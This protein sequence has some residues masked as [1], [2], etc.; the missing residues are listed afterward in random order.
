MIRKGVDLAMRLLGKQFVTGETIEEALKSASP[1][2]ARGYRFSYDML[3][4]AAMTAAD[5]AALPRLLRA[6]DPRHR[7]GEPGRGI[8]VGPGI[9]VK[10]SA[11]HPR[12]ARAQHER[13]MAELLPRLKALLLLARGYDIGLNIDAEEADRLELSLDLLEAL[14]FDPEL[15]GWNGIG[16]VVQA[17]QK[18]CPFVLDWLIDLARRSG[19]RFMVRLVKGAYWDSE[20]KRAQVDGQD[21]YPVYTRK[22]HTDVAYLACAKKL[23]AARR[24]STRSSPPT[25]PTRWPPSTS[26]RPRQPGLRVP[27]PARH[28]RAALRRRSWAARTSSTGRAAS[29]PRSAPTRRC[30]PTWC[31]ACSRTAP[32]PPSSTGWST[33][34]CRRRA[35][36]RPG[37]HGRGTAAEG[38]SRCRTTAS[39]AARPL[40]RASA[41]LAGIDLASEHATCRAG[42][43]RWPSG[44]ALDA[45]PIL[46]DGPRDAG[47]GAAVRNPADHRDLV[48]T[49]REATHRRVEARLPPPRRGAALGRDRRRPSARRCLERA[50]DLLEA[51]C[52]A[53][54]ALAVREA[55]K[56]LPNAIGRGARGGRLL[57]LLRGRIRAEFETNATG[58]PLGPVVCISPWNF[59]LAIFTGEVAA[60]LAA[61]NPVLAKPAEQTPLIAAEAVRLFHRA[62]VPADV[63]QL[64][65]GQRRNG[66]RGALVADPRVQGVIFTGSTEVAQ[67]INRSSPSAAAASRS[68]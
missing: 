48:G 9:S 51:R 68:R 54:M 4:E 5:A 6:G 18:R 32:T 12:Y 35:G 66:G 56:T 62:G 3:G 11:L 60:A 7:Q 45:A 41:E 46:A 20:I 63:L 2:E 21:G 33:P 47:N 31:A 17:Y 43:R 14:A 57:P 38:R 58:R 19:H 16:F 67:L 49:V 15:A 10:L 30:S 28:G 13:V 39:P 65:P 8:Y 23:L 37:R 26:W 50:A 36:R 59:P 52:A 42:R 61:G 44:R 64:L 29:T 24:R 53:L 55:G 22:V 34:R 25:T 1:R 40:R 27:V